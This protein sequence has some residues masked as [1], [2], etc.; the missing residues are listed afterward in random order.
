M[1]LFNSKKK[2]PLAPLFRSPC[3]DRW[4]II[5][6]FLFLKPPKFELFAHAIA[7]NYLSWPDELY[8]L[9]LSNPGPTLSICLGPDCEPQPHRVLTFNSGPALV[10]TLYKKKWLGFCTDKSVFRKDLLCKNV[11]PYSPPVQKP[12]TVKS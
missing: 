5:I 1:F 11:Q 12:L 10:Q 9:P 3:S 6:F 2:P 4:G 7:Q 8:K